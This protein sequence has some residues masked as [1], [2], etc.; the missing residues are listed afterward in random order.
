MDL[1]GS[2]SLSKSWSLFLHLV[3]SP[4]L[5]SESLAEPEREPKLYVEW[6][7]RS[8]AQMS[9]G[10]APFSFLA[11][12]LPNTSLWHSFSRTLSEVPNPR[13]WWLLHVAYARAMVHGTPRYEGAMVRNWARQIFAYDPPKWAGDGIFARRADKP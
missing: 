7:Y 10:W 8:F 4:I 11:P 9:R 12:G 5:I 1:A 2:V 3:A 6:Q 13:D